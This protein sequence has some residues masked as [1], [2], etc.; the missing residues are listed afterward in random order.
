[1]NVRPP[2][3]EVYNNLEKYF[4]YTNLDKPII[5]DSPASPSPQRRP[6]ISRTF[7]SANKSPVA[8]TSADSKTRTTS[9]HPSEYVV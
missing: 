9:N 7:S 4:P 5:D 3:E 1:M 6:T 2:V 8:P